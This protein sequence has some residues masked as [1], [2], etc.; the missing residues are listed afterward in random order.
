MPYQERVSAVFE[1]AV[2]REPAER[3][4]Y[5]HEACEGDTDL[6]QQVE[7]LLVDVERPALIDSPV[8][9]A[10][11]ELLGDDSAVVIAELQQRS[12]RRIRLVCNDTN[13]G[14]VSRQWASGV[15][16]D[17]EPADGAACGDG[18]LAAALRVS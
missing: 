13:S 6:R 11:V 12:G 3:E 9:Q 17:A 1:A 10:V 5:L 14:S 7:A 18:L 4:A 15:S 8:G 16:R 2:L